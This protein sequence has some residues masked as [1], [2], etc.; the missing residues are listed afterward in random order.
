MMSPTTN[1]VSPEARDRAV[2]M[3]PAHELDRE[4]DKRPA[5]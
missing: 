2:R 3:V 1:K 4:V 5:G